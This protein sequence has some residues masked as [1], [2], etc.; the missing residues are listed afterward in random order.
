MNQSTP[1]NRQSATIAAETLNH[2]LNSNGHNQLAGCVQIAWTGECGSD[3]T[4]TQNW[5][6]PIG[7]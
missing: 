4:K 6:Q 2:R 7:G 1:N 5:I 3:G